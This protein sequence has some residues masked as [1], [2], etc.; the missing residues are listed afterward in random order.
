MEVA[1]PFRKGGNGQAG[2]FGSCQGVL[3][4]QNRAILPQ[5]LLSARF[6]P[7]AHDFLIRPAA[8][9]LAEEGPRAVRVGARKSGTGRAAGCGA[10]RPSPLSAAPRPL[11]RDFLRGEEGRDARG[12]LR[13][14]GAHLIPPH[15]GPPRPWGGPGP[16][17]V[18]LGRPGPFGVRS[19]FSTPLSPPS[20]LC[21]GL[22]PVQ[23][24]D[25]AQ[26]RTVSLSC[27]SSLETECPPGQGCW[28]S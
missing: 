18:G 17:P 3:L 26:G 1:R 7:C 22:H 9:G 14:A 27:P 15:L 12:R 13:R 2:P 8:S 28:R 10:G 24:W 23:P 16:A 6:P 4:S 11:T 21:R 25:H 20:P 19:G 5:T